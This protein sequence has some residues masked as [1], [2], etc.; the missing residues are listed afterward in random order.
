MEIMIRIPFI[1]CETIAI[2]GAIINST[3]EQLKRY[4]IS[5]PLIHGLGTNAPLNN[6]LNLVQDFKNIY[7]HNDV[8][9]YSSMGYYSVM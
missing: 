4:N 8:R 2:E 5:N 9:S 6:A 3:I 1:R 7:T